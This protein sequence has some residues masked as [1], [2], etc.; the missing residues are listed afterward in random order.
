MVHQLREVGRAD[1]DHLTALDEP[2]HEGEELGHHALLDVAD[3]LRA[4]RGEGVDLVEED[5]AGRVLPRLL[6]DGAQPGFALPVVLVDDLGPVHVDEVGLHLERGGAG[7]EGLAGARW[8]DQQHPPR[9][10]DAERREERG[11][12][13]RQLDHLADEG[14]LA[15]EPADVLVGDPGCLALGELGGPEGELRV[16]RDHQGAPGA[17]ALHDERPRPGAEPGDLEAI[18]EEEGPAG[19]QVAE[20]GELGVGGQGESGLD[21][22]EEHRGGGPERGAPDADPVVHARLR[23]ASG[24]PVDQDE[25]LPAVALRRRGRARHGGASAGDEER[26]A[27]GRVKPGE[28][29]RIEPGPSAAHVVEEGLGDPERLLAG[30]RCAHR[31]ARLPPPAHGELQLGDVTRALRQLRPRVL[32]HRGSVLCDG[33][34]LV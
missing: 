19:E 3:D 6:E 18:A 14:D 2:V 15:V 25:L 5:D 30:F 27:G 28:I 24:A 21:G 16:R 8:S 12:A 34:Q 32:A 20:R 22:G 9:R 17:R 23:V 31:T 13:E 4:L 1:D 10:L 11:A 7:D 26:I 29:R 33:Y